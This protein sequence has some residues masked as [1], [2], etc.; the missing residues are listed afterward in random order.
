MLWLVGWRPGMIVSWLYWGFRI[1]LCILYIHL[2]GD[3]AGLP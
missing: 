3:T 1:Y 2:L